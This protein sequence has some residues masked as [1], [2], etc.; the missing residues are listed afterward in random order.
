MRV[1][2]VDALPERAAAVEETLRSVGH[3]VIV[4]LDPQTDLRE[5]V[6]RLAPDLVIIDV[7]SPNRDM[8]EGMHALNRDR[9]RPVV[10]FT[11]D[12]NPDLIRAAV[13]AGV[14][15]YV[16]G[17]VQPAR[18]LPVLTVAITRFEQ[19]QSIRRELDDARCALADRK[20]IER[21]KGILMKQKQMDEA[22]AYGAMRSMAMDRN[23]KLSELAR[24]LIAAAELLA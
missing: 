24:S 20:L 23:L 5:E 12:D 11:E 9:P 21:A 17:D 10:I 18:V 22:A 8:L 2:L 6:A 3:D 19:F 4:R 15:A 14:S 13:A 7:D 1:L 16:V